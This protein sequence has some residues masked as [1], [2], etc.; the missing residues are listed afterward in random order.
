MKKIFATL[1][2]CL[3]ILTV[4]TGCGAK[5]YPMGEAMEVQEFK[6]KDEDHKCDYCSQTP[7]ANFREK[8]E[9]DEENTAHICEECASKFMFCN[10]K[11]AYYYKNGLGTVVFV[12][13][14]CYKEAKDSG[15][16]K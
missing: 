2:A 10:K 11:S 13:K 8:G 5:V 6:F 16:L 15:I 9:K 4:F 12:C 7:V 3:L 14:D 1:L